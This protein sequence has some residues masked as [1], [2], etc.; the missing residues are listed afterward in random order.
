[1]LPPP[2]GWG[3]QGSPTTLTER[4]ASESSI[5]GTQTFQLGSSFPMDMTSET[6]QEMHRGVYARVS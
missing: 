4:Y 3:V 5:L 2:T 6:M 1:M